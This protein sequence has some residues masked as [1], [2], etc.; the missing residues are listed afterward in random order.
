MLALPGTRRGTGE[1]SPPPGN[2]CRIAPPERIQS[3][4][5]LRFTVDDQPGVLARVASVMARERVS[6]ASVLQHPAERKG[7]ASL[8][9]TTHASDERAVRRALR[10]LARLSSVLETPLLLRIG[11]FAD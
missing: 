8:V 2:R 4:Y 11:D 7:A 5:Y 1:D 3:R 6:I 9:L 10:N